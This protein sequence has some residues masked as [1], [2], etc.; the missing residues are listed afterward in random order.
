MKRELPHRTIAQIEEA[1]GPLNRY[2]CSLSLGRCVSDDE[3]LMRHFA[4][5]GGAE[6]FAIRYR[7]ALSD[8]N[9]WF[10]SEFYDREITDP[11]TLWHYYNNRARL[12]RPA[13][14]APQNSST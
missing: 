14:A 12:T 8:T 13:P 7:H 6:D 11:A 4:S 3:T 9:K 5:S 10:C 2:Y 1:R